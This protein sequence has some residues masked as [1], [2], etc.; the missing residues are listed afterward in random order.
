M[1][2]RSAPIAASQHV[3][4]EI[5]AQQWVEDQLD[6]DLELVEDDSMV[7]HMKEDVTSLRQLARRVQDQGG[8]MRSGMD[9]EMERKMRD[10]AEAH[11]QE[12]HAYQAKLERQIHE[13]RS[14]R[15]I[16]FAV[17][18]ALLSWWYSYCIH[19]VRLVDT[20]LVWCCG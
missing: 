20:T 7:E 18:V 4:T 12:L 8:A 15:D 3:L 16:A 11:K 2:S 14:R 13:M 5:C 19:T 10:S 1:N 17:V 9:L 6:E